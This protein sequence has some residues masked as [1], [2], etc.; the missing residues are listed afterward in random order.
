MHA[1][2]VDLAVLALNEWEG[3]S[4]V[5]VSAEPRCLRSCCHG[6]RYLFVAVYCAEI[7]VHGDIAVEDLLAGEVEKVCPDGEIAERWHRRGA[8]VG[9]DKNRRPL[10]PTT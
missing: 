1:A 5:R 4:S 8:L 10:T 3:T 7:L 2:I 9:A 6:D